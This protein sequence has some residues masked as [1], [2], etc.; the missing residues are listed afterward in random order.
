[1]RK[2]CC[3]L[4]III[5]ISIGFYSVAFLNFVI[6]VGVLAVRSAWFT[7]LSCFFIELGF[8]SIRFLKEV[9]SLVSRILLFLNVSFMLKRWDICDYEIE[10]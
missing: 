8:F 4:N 10:K 5:L 6:D 1:M 3:L 9:I 7:L 2:S